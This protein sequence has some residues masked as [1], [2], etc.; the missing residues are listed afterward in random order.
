MR[1]IKTL[2]RNIRYLMQ[3]DLQAELRKEKSQR[4][5]EDQKLEDRITH[6]EYIAPAI[7]PGEN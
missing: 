7:K 2:I 6:K 4:F 3:V 5:R 1:K